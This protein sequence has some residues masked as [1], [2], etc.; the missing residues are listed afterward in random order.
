MQQIAG[1]VDD[2]AARDLT[3]LGVVVARAN[4]DQL[5]KQRGIV[6]GAEVFE[7]RDLVAKLVDLGCDGGIAGL[8]LGDEALKLCAVRREVGLG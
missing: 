7:K 6:V 5:V 8:S 4:I 1:V 3:L 2:L